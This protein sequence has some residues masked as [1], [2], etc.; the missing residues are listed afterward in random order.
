[1]VWSWTIGQSRPKNYIVSSV[2]M[3]SLNILEHLDLEHEDS[4]LQTCFYEETAIGK[5]K[6]MFKMLL[7]DNGQIDMGQQDS[8][9]TFKLSVCVSTMEANIGGA[10]Q[11]CSESRMGVYFCVHA[12]VSGLS[13]VT[14]VPVLH[15][16][17]SLSLCLF[18]SLSFFLPASLSPVH[19]SLLDS[20]HYC[21]GTSSACPAKAR[22]WN[23]IWERGGVWEIVNEER[24]RDADREREWERGKKG[25]QTREKG[26]K[27][28]RNWAM[29]ESQGCC[30]IIKSI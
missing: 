28:Q 6:S 9:F 11:C 12:C 24:E 4:F 14:A 3:V 18:V 2:D 29:L 16:H 23:G 13:V 19:L 7:N 20:S 5:S 15:I 22:H 17:V 21:L 1:M 30:S 25:N 8:Q 10:Q 27:R 26:E